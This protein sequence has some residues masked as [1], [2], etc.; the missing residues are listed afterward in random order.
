[1]ARTFTNVVGFDDAPFS[2]DCRGDVAIFGVVCSRTRLDGLVT[3]PVRR[4]GVN[5]TARIV[6]LVSESRFREHVQAVLLDGIALAG[7]NVVDI[8]QVHR[9]L[10]VPVLV[11]TRR[12]PDLAK[13]RE[14]LCTRV[15]GGA[16]KWR[17]IERAGPPEALRGLF[18]QRAGLDLQEAA[19]L[20]DAT[21]LQG[22]LPE[23]LRLA[24][25]I[26]SGVTEG[27]SRGGA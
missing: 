25:I 20:I 5:A 13:I 12:P 17:R 18:V 15:R 3:G 24:H 14:A 10:G 19:G 27:R 22:K 11:V 26:A 9:A 1:M 23:P 16:R 8:H 4:D 21:T 7:F 6:E 2:R